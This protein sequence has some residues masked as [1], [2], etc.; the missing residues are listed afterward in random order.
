MSLP[1]LL[2]AGGQV[3]A[4]QCWTCSWILPLP[5]HPSLSFLTGLQ[6][7]AWKQIQC[8]KWPQLCRLTPS[9]LNFVVK[10]YLHVFPRA[11]KSAV[12]S[13]GRCSPMLPMLHEPMPLQLVNEGV[14]TSASSVGLPFHCAP[15]Q[16]EHISVG[17]A[18][19]RW[20]WLS[21]HHR[22]CA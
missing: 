3:G 18:P 20:R 16:R 8:L 6:D 1:S 4:Q 7:K 12:E 19:A 13:L 10:M 5:R 2:C 21:A 14:R 11:V 15:P 9:T 17:S 22:Q